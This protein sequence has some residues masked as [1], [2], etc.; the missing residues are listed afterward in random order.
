MEQ[1]ASV[2]I[3]VVGDA[4]LPNS[5]TGRRVFTGDAAQA[6]ALIEE[7]ERHALK[8]LHIWDSTTGTNCD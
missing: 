7:L 5:C 4:P 3:V 8:V 6:G 1:N 2:V